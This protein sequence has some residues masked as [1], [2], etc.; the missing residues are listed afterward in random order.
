MGKLSFKL[1]SM[2]ALWLPVAATT[3]AYVPGQTNWYVGIDTLSTFTSGAF[4]GQANPNNG[5]LTFLYGHIYSGAQASSSHYHAKSSLRLYRE[6]VG[7]PILT[8]DTALSVNAQGVF[9]QF[10]NFVPETSNT[11]IRLGEGTGSFAGRYRTGVL[12]NSTEW[13]NMEFRPSSYLNRP[14]ASVGEIATYNTS[15]GRYTG[16]LGSRTIGLRIESLSAGL[17]AWDPSGTT[18]LNVGDVLT[19]GSGDFA[20]TPIFSTIA[21]V[22]EGVRLNATVRLV[23]LNDSSVNSGTTEF[24]FQT[25]PEPATMAAIGV[26]LVALA[27]KRKKTL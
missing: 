2:A 14:G 22:G 8:S 16:S 1:L 25:V 5:R 19:L 26:G 24:R 3:F 20:S 13:E 4:S 12:G 9:T 6:T 21:G 27:R 23:D 10:I 7:G 18:Q 11:F 15:G 17:Q